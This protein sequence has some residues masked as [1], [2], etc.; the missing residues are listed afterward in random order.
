VDAIL[1]GDGLGA[2]RFSAPEAE[3]VAALEKVHGAPLRAVPPKNTGTPW[4]NGCTAG[5]DTMLGFPSG[6][7]VGLSNGRFTSW[8]AASARGVDGYLRTPAGLTWGD[9][10]ATTQERYGSRYRSGDLL[11]LYNW[12]PN[13]RVVA[14]V[15]DSGPVLLA[16]LDMEGRDWGADR[17][18]L[19]T[20]GSGCVGA[21]IVMPAAD[22][23]LGQRFTVRQDR[24]GGLEYRLLDAA[25]SSPTPWRSLA[26]VG[27]NESA[28]AFARVVSDEAPD[29][30]EAWVAQRVDRDRAQEAWLVTDRLRSDGSLALRFGMCAMRDGGAVGFAAVRSSDDARPI[31][32]VVVDVTTA[33]F[34]ERDLSDLECLLHDVEGEPA[35]LGPDAPVPAPAG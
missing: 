7:L 6:L 16:T 20:A 35:P 33:R 11:P 22:P 2:V 28:C 31:S 3:I 9:T 23:P 1:R 18:W 29:V 15:D 8:T 17:V 32:I 21:P 10:L 26:G 34:V 4:A 12:G 24:P 5:G 30:S 25:T 13:V 14:T 27:C 19:M